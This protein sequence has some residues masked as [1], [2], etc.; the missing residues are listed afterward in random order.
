MM[1][2]MKPFIKDW[3]GLLAAE[4]HSACGVFAFSLQDPQ[5]IELADEI[6]S[7]LGINYSPSDSWESLSDNCQKLNDEKAPTE[8]WKV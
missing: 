1:G 3:W 7:L 2:D 5:F 8:D 6:N 4:T